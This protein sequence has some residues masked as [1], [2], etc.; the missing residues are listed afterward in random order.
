METIKVV[1]WNVNSIRIR[2]SILKKL[3]EDYYPDIVCIQ[4]VKAKEED[5]PF[6]DIKALGFEN[7]A[8]Y[9][10]AGYNGVAVL[11]KL[12]IKNIENI[13]WV[14]KKDARHIRV[15]VLDDIEI[16]NIYIPAGGDIPDPIINLSFAHKLCF[17]DD[18]S[19]FFELNKENLKDKKMILCGDFNVAPSEYDVWNHKQLTKIVSHT[20]IEIE[21]LSRLFNSLN[22][23]DVIRK[24]HPDPEKIFSWWSYRNP[25]WLTN[26]KGRR[27]D[28]IWTTRNLENRIV[29]AKILKEFRSFD[30]PSDHVPVMV[31]L[32]NL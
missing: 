8:L 16:N 21:R 28:H 31:E 12:P 1:T 10:M 4:E 27:L 11:S 29:S 9:G 25:N 32:L 15:T 26:N 7:I 24:F 3:V 18:I 13:D 2:L 6:R 23:V 20:P 19:E 30:R 5:F 22:F 14:G 17:M